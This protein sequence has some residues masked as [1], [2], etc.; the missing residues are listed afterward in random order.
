MK[1]IHATI[2]KL[3]ATGGKVIFEIG[4]HKGED[5]AHL[6]SIKGSV[7]HAFECDPR[8]ILTRLPANVRINYSAVSNHNGTQDFWLSEKPGA[9]WTCSSSLLLP[10]K[11]LEEHP[12]IKFDRR[13]EVRCTTLDTYCESNRI[14]A[15]DFIWMD[16]QGAEHLVF[17]GGNSILKNTH[18]IFTEYADNEQF[19]TQ[20]P[21]ADLLLILGKNWRVVEKWDYDVLLINDNFKM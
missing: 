19:R 9:Q 6:A 20:K 16:V 2:A 1:T 7:V 18:F 10:K 8:N 3:I 12:Q 13:V 5:T 14:E 21:L 17:E 4:A 11:H 15:I